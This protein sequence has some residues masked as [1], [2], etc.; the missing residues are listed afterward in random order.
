[1]EKSSFIQWFT[2]L[3]KLDRKLFVSDVHIKECISK[4]VK[5]V[6]NGK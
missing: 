1:M 4:K 2:Q 6:M 5:R 3:I